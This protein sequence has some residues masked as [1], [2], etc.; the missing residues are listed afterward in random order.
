MSSLEEADEGVSTR[1][2]VELR[3]MADLPDSVPRD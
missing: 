3:E 1:T 2:A